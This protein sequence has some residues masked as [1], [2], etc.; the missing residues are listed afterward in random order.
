MKISMLIPDDDL[1]LIDA[2]AEP[3][4]TAFMIRAS[5]EAALRVQ[6]ERE[7]A[8]IARICTESAERDRALAEESAGTAADGL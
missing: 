4:R 2:V 6:R 1:A 3:N 7:D 8:E 5:K